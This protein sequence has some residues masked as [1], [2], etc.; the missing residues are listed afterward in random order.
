MNSK[1]NQ[2]WQ[3]ILTKFIFEER[4]NSNENEQYQPSSYAER[5]RSNKLNLMTIIGRL[6][7]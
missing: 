6:Q 4:S 7:Q 2:Q 1:N 5:A 3:Q